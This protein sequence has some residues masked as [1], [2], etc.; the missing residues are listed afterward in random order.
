VIGWVRFEGG[1]LQCILLVVL[2][3]FVLSPVASQCCRSA[4]DSTWSSCGCNDSTA[5][6]TLSTSGMVGT[7]IGGAES[8]GHRL[9]P[10]VGR[11]TLFGRLQ[12]TPGYI[13]EVRLAMVL[14]WV[15]L[16]PVISSRTWYGQ[17]RNIAGPAPWVQVGVFLG[18]G[19]SGLAL[20][21]AGWCRAHYWH[22]PSYTFVDAASAAG[23]LWT[24]LCNCL[25]YY[26]AGGSNQH[27]SDT[28]L[29][30]VGSSDTV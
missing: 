21:R 27:S 20:S 12:G 24:V 15:G 23:L 5:S 14:V 13:T 26:A 6:A 18:G 11:H 22:I 3:A 25:R 4:V 28:A 10:T 8:V 16:G 1:R 2:S 19:G 9:L 30:A 17:V 29:L 7:F